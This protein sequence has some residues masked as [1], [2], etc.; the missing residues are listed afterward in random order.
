MPVIDPDV[1]FHGNVS[2]I[3][4]A[5]RFLEMEKMSY[6]AF[7]KARA[8]IYSQAAF[9]ANRDIGKPQIL[10]LFRFL[11]AAH[12]IKFTCLVLLVSK[13]LSLHLTF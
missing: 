9:E 3:S 13:V 10:V 7:M 11:V 12:K 5:F 1:S 2:E 6:Y 4:S 8:L